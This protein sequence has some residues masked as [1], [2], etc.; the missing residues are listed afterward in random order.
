MARYLF[1]S[2]MNNSGSTLLVRYL[3]RC[4]NSICM[5]REGQSYVPHAMP[6][7]GRLGVQR[8]WSEAAKIFEDPASYDWFAV[9]AAWIREWSLDP[10]SKTA[11]LL[12]LSDPDHAP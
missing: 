8:I 5:E 2:C 7:V 1:V 10:K 4:A 9:K 11:D 3:A 12:R 6:G